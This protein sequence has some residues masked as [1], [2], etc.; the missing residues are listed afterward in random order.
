MFREIK[1]GG[2]FYSASGSK[3]FVKTYGLKR[4]V[5]NIKHAEV[6]TKIIAKKKDENKKKDMFPFNNM[7]KW[8]LNCQN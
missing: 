4:F 8:R 7:S 2:A 3:K 6:L 5:F 1:I